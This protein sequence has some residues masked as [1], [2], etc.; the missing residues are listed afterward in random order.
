MIVKNIAMKDLKKNFR[1]LFNRFWPLLAIV[2]IVFVFFWKVFLKGLV[3]IPGDLIVGAYYP[4]LDY[5]WGYEVGVPVKNP[6]TSDVVSVIYPLR[7]LAVDVLKQGKL[8]LW[9]PHM[10]NGYPLLANFQVAI[11][12]PTIFFYFLFPKII[13]WTAQIIAQPILAALFTYLLLR[14]LKLG[15]FPSLV[16]GL[17][18]A[19]SGFNMIWLEWNA[20]ALVAAWIPLILLLTSKFISKGKISWGVLL[21]I[22]LAVQILSGYPQLAIYTVAALLLFLF[23]KRDELNFRKLSLLSLFLLAGILLSFVQTLPAYELFSQSQRVSEHLDS[24]LIYLP[25][26]NLITFFAPDYFGNHATGNFWGVGNYTLNT[27]YTGVVSIILGTVGAFGYFKKKEV[28]YFVFLLLIS[29]A[30]ALPTPIAK[31][32]VESKIPGLAAASPTRILVFSNLSLAILAAFGLNRLISKKERVHIGVFCVPAIVLGGVLIWTLCTGLSK[33]GLRNLILPISFVTL[34]SVILIVR[35]RLFSKKTLNNFLVFAVAFIAVFELFRYGWKYTPFS[36][37]DLVFP[38]TPVLEFLKKQ[39]KPFR[40]VPGDVILPVNMWVAYGIEAPIGYDAVYPARLAKFMSVVQFGDPD[41]SP[42]GR[43]GSIT[44]YDSPLLDLVNSN[45]VLAV[46][47]D[48]GISKVFK[49]DKL[50]PVFRDKSVVVL[51]NKK[52]LP[53]A[54]FVSQWEV[55]Q[56]EDIFRKLLS[57]NFPFQEKIIIE[58]DFKRF[59]QNEKNESEVSFVEYDSQTSKVKV[60]SNVPGFL[61]VSDTW[62]PDW[63]ALVDGKEE[64]ILRANYAFRAVPVSEGEHIVEFIYDPKSF[65]IGKWLSMATIISLITLLTYDQIR[66]NSRKA[67]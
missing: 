25:W 34:T 41:T 60:K 65:K 39:E 52:V 53:R 30:L 46:E 57:D 29:L 12:S 62:Y 17:I 11:F 44:R 5:K 13:A 22:A 9:N 20:H 37:Q 35:Y 67:S 10:F 16:G 6:I 7:S 50:S 51:E 61:F 3:P 19:F 48:E 42:F 38:D 47:K 26:Q 31:I 2:F 1:L 54:F 66:K 58:E 21:S 14:H 27:G 15:K 4:W 32:V 49:L 8:P 36:S 24:N 28:W 63:K 23:F 18:Y 40:I 45:Y 56:D 55:A 43:Y 33:V 64:K 59:N